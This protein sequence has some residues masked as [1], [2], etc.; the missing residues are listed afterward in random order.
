MAFEVHITVV[1]DTPN[2][3]A[4]LETSSTAFNHIPKAKAADEAEHS[5]W[6]VNGTFARC[7]RCD[8][9]YVNRLAED[10]KLD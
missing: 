9:N 6:Y 5:G 1:C 8:S 7:P 3:G 2:C 10:V 4:R